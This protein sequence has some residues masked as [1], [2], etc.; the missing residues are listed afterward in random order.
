MKLSKT[1][2]KFMKK[3]NKDKDA[4]TAELVPQVCMHA[5]L[6]PTFLL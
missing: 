1:Q 5:N 2:F 6:A 4:L 3:L